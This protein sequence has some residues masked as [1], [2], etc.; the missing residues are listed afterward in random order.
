MVSI[1]GTR[2]G[3]KYRGGKSLCP[4]R[5]ISVT[6]TLYDT[7]IH[8]DIVSSGCLEES[9][10]QKDDERGGVNKLI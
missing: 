7:Q 10:R 1:P 6:L 5:D 9:S 8:R 2:S 4:H 3:T